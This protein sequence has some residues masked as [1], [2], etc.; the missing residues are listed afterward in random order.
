MAEFLMK[1][2]LEKLGIA[3]E[4]FVSS[5]AV[6]DEEIYSG[7]GN[8]VYPPVKRLLS[9]INIDCSAKRAQ[10]IT[11]R[12][13]P[14][15]DYFLCMDSYNKRNLLKIFGSDTENKVFMLLDFVKG[16][17]DNEVA[18]PYYYGGYDKVFSDINKGIDGFLTHLNIK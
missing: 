10:T 13:Y 12:D 18:D 6:S 3:N 15:F 4:F 11:S 7:V 16:I 2:K 17:E 5:H 8:P 9:E 1:D 14:K